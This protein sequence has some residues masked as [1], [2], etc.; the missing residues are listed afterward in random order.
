MVVNKDFGYCKVTSDVLEFCKGTTKVSLTA[1][2]IKVGCFVE[3]DNQILK[4]IWE[5]KRLILDKTIL[6]KK[7]GNFLNFKIYYKNYKKFHN[8]L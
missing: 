5:D 4:F 2:E 7:K 8:L 1:I 6:K 3:I